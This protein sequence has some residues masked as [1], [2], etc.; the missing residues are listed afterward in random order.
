MTQRSTLLS[1]D[2]APPLG[3]DPRTCHMRR[4]RG[5][6]RWHLALPR[7]ALPRADRGVSLHHQSVRPALPLWLK[8]SPDG[9]LGSRE[10]GRLRRAF[11][12][13]RCLTGLR[14]E[15]DLDCL[16]RALDLL[17]RHRLDDSGMFDFHIPRAQQCQQLAV[18]GGLV[19]AHLGNCRWTA[20]P[21]VSEQ[22]RNKLAV[23]LLTVT[24]TDRTAGSEIS[25]TKIPPTGGVQRVVTNCW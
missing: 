7:R 15:H 6:W 20:V 13:F 25:K 23:Q 5:R 2:P 24:R 9:R 12:D 3:L 4:S 10:R 14:R 17:V 18:S 11:N 21:E 22:G 8:P 19:L 16:N 1:A